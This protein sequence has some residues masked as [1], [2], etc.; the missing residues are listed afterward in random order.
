MAHNGAWKKA[1]DAVVRVAS[2]VMQYDTNG[3]DIYFV[4]S[5]LHRDAIMVSLDLS[6]SL[7]AARQPRRRS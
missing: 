1:R 5:L 2:E 7:M 6:S 3:I 4:N